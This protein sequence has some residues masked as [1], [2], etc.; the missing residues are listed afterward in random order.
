MC[1][2]IWCV[3]LVS[4]LWKSFVWRCMISVWFTYD[5][6]TV[7]YITL[8]YYCMIL[9]DFVCFL[10]YVRT[11]CICLYVFCTS[12]EWLLFFLVWLCMICVWFVYDCCMLFE[13]CVVQDLCKIDL[14]L[15]CKIVVWFVNVFECVL[16]VLCMM[17]V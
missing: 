5:F 1:V 4:Y 7:W 6:C 13:W 2:H 15:L 9:Y 3:W 8:N 16:Y 12:C 17:V 11:I 14:H 10:Y